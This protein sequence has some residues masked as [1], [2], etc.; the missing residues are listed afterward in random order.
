MTSLCSAFLYSHSFA[1]VRIITCSYIVLSDPIFAFMSLV[2]VVHSF[3]IN[4]EDKCTI[5]Q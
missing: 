2:T 1:L 5:L 3:L 4:L